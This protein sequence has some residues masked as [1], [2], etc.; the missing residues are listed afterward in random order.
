MRGVCDQVCGGVED[1]AREVEA[2]FY[3][4]GR[5]GLFERYTHLLGYRHEERVEDLKPDGICCSR[6]VGGFL[7]GD[8]LEN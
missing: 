4:Y 5:G 1:G 3:V 8:A 7:Y 6:S 2:L